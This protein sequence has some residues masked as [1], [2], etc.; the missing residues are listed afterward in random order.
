MVI[1]YFQVR[2]LFPQ[3][4]LVFFLG[5]VR[6]VHGFDLPCSAVQPVIRAALQLP[7]NSRNMNAQLVRHLSRLH[8]HFQPL[9]YVQILVG[10]G[11]G[12][13]SA[14]IGAG[15]G[16]VVTQTAGYNVRAVKV[17]HGSF[18]LVAL[19]VIYPQPLCVHF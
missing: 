16:R 15:Q 2:P 17:L 18:S 14:G 7:V 4:G 3:V 10:V 11:V 8:P 12:K 6:A 9:F 19:P 13:I 1:A 5:N